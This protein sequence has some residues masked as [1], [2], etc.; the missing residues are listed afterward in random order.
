MAQDQRQ[1]SW[2][3]IAGIAFALLCVASCG[4]SASNQ[5]I[6][7]KKLWDAVRPGTVTPLAELLPEV[8]TGYVC[9][10]GPYEEETR[11]TA[12]D[13]RRINEYLRSIHYQ[14]DEGHWILAIVLPDRIEV[15][16]FSRSDKLDFDGGGRLLKADQAAAV[17]GNFSWASCMP[18]ER[19]AFLWSRDGDRTYG[20]FG[21]QD[22]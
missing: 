5:L 7:Q 4:N 11:D 14:S 17:Q 12:P 6:T 9:A 1:P 21:A 8:S 13:G 3:H 19:A 15:S 2:P 18:L 16:R 22:H 20:T 10:M